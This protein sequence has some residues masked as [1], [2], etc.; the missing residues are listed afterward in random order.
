FERLFAD[1]TVI[2]IAH[3]LSTVANADKIVVVDAGSVKEIGTHE[4]LLAA[5]GTYAGI[6][7][8]AGLT[9]PVQ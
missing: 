7:A 1:R 3:R 9:G 8:A 5:G 4:Q 2:V 6:Y